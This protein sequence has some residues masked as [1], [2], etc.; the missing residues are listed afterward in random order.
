MNH[1]RGQ[2][3]STGRQRWLTDFLLPE[4]TSTPKRWFLLDDEHVWI[5]KQWSQLYAL[6]TKDG[7]KTSEAVSGS[8]AIKPTQGL[9]FL[10]LLAYHSNTEFFCMSDQTNEIFFKYYYNRRDTVKTKQRDNSNKLCSYPQH[11]GDLKDNCGFPTWPTIMHFIDWW[12]AP[13]EWS[14]LEVLLL[15][16]LNWVVVAVRNKYAKFGFS[17][18]KT[19]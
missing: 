16:L 19:L 15:K 12:W 7:G 8:M 3:R 5:H 10:L 17:Y 11:C 18:F 13:E 1:D 6:L 9:C 4:D 14:G 2:K